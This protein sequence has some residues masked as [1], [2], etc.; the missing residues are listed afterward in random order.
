MGYANPVEAMGCS[1]FAEAAR[2]SG[3]D[4]VLTVDYPPEESVEFVTELKARGIDPIFLLSP[5]TEAARVASVVNLASGFIY[6]VS[7][8]GVTGAQHLDIDDVAS[9]LAAIRSHTELPVGVGFGVRDA[10]TAA[11]I[12]RIADAVVVG[13]RMVQEMENS[14]QDTV[15]SNLGRLTAVLRSAIDAH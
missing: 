2:E 12:A 3:V 5:T 4:G 6:Y 13:S 8:K 1:K 15:A 9:K 10:A 11:A 14:T 7:L